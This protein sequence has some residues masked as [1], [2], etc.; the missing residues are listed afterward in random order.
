MRALY[1]AAVEEKAGKTSLAVGLARACAARGLAVAYR[2]PVGWAS[3]YRQG[4]QFD[5]DAEVV[6]K[7]LG[8]AEPPEELVPVLAGETPRAWRPPEGAWD[9]ILVVK[10]IPADLLLLEGRQWLG[11]GLLSVLSDPATAG[12]LST[13]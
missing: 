9:R 1:L 12:R 11:R 8:L 13:P 6:A 2:K 3:T 7:A 5:R 4:R 10:E